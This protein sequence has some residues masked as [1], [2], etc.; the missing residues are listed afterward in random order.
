MLA[1][2]DPRFAMAY[3]P[4]DAGLHPIFVVLTERNCVSM[5]AMKEWTAFKIILLGDQTADKTSLFMRFHKNIWDPTFYQTSG[6]IFTKTS[7][8]C[9]SE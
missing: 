9:G 7:I 1:N 5:L 3:S 4:T 8:T 6:E 2:D